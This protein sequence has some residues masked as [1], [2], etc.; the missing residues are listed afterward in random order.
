MPGYNL[1]SIDCN[2]IVEF[3]AAIHCITKEI[4]VDKPFWI[5][6]AKPLLACTD[7][8]TTIKVNAAHSSGVESLLFNYWTNTNPDPQQISMSLFDVENEYRSELSPITQIADTLFYYFEG[9]AQNGKQIT[10]PLPAPEGFFKIPIG[11]CKGVGIQIVQDP[12]N[13]LLIYPNPASDQ[14]YVEI[15]NE[16]FFDKSFEVFVVDIEGKS[17][18]PRFEFQSSSS[19]NTIRIFL[20]QLK[21]GLYFL[22]VKKGAELFSER[23]FIKKP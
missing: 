3:T 23:F 11:L 2:S 17:I 5:S 9:L 15:K 1:V 21:T 4:G 22:M 7:E 12:R 6:H 13:A 8:P 10:R 19:K 14:L 16:T 18:S 20:P